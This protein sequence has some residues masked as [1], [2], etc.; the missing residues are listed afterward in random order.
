L[1]KKSPLLPVLLLLLPCPPSFLGASL[2]AK[3][4]RGG[5]PQ[6]PSTPEC[7]PVRIPG[8][9][10]G[11]EEEHKGGTPSPGKKAA[12]V[13]MDKAAS[14]W[15]WWWGWC[16]QAAAVVVVAVAVAVAGEGWGGGGCGRRS[17]AAA[18]GAALPVGSKALLLA[19][20]GSSSTPLA[21]REGSEAW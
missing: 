18:P 14:S 19:L 2:L 12:G 9:G 21:A 6:G 7:A 5:S 1:L 16:V 8:W 20:S 13:A 10:E 15:G 3:A 4:E 17:C 11:K